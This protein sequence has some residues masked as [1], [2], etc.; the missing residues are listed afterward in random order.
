MQLP[1]K[2]T[3]LDATVAL[4]LWDQRPDGSK[5]LV[6]RG[7]YRLSTAAGDPASGVLRTY[8]SGNDWV[9]PAGDTIVLQVTQDDAPYLRPDNEPSTIT[10]SGM[11]L[12]LPTRSS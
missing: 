7:E 4:K 5:T 10:W 12:G 3:G 11:T 6:S 9:F 8:L 1:Y 2:L